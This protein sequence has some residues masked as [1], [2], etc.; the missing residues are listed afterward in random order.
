[1]GGLRSAP[2]EILPVMNSAPAARAAA[3][4]DGDAPSQQFVAT[5]HGPAFGA[6]AAVQRDRLYLFRHGFIFTS[7]WVQTTSTVRYPGVLPSPFHTPNRKFR[8]IRT[9]AANSC[10]NRRLGHMA[11][12]DESS[13]VQ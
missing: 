6:M 3:L 2:F 8:L 9:T 7:A 10:T 4:S 12:F 1:L 13:S 11:A 5:R